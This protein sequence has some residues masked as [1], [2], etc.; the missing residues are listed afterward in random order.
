MIEANN[1]E[2]VSDVVV[3]RGEIRLA[4]RGQLVYEK[5]KLVRV[6][7]LSC[8]C[9]FALAAQKHAAAGS[10]SDYIRVSDD[11]VDS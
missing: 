3:L 1:A 2:L 11:R 4:S 8:R 5:G 10:I 7:A 6:S 9:P